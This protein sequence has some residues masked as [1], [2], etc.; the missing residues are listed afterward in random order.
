MRAR[1]VWLVWCFLVAPGF[2]GANDDT[3]AVKVVSHPPRRANLP[4]GLIP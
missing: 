3:A 4:T 2:V 1:D